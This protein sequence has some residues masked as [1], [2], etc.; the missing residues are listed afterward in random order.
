MRLVGLVA[1]VA[2]QVAFAG[3]TPPA[4]AKPRLLVLD[5]VPAGGVEPQVAGALTESVVAEASRTGYFEVSAQREMR[6]LVGL[7]RERA[8]MGCSEDSANCLAE[9][10]GAMGVRFVLSGTVARL[11]EAYQLTLQA[12]DSGK[13]Q[14]VGRS[15]RIAK[16]LG[17][18]L[19]SV[20]YA[21]A[22]ATA[23]PPPKPPSRVLPFTL[24]G[25]GGALVLVGGVVAFQAF[26]REDTLVSELKLAES[27][28]S[29]V[30]RPVGFYREEAR[31][32]ANQ[33]LIGS[34]L[35]GAGV[36]L[37]VTGLTLN[38]N[39]SSQIELRVAWAPGGPG[40]AM[41]GVF[42]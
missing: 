30:L 27:Q 38:L 40:V 33:K 10:A 39:L 36:A 4:P 41:A 5:L 15:T 35:S 9:M 22:E 3:T 1:L 28:P 32:I 20:P 34:L 13:A 21:L 16:D 24:I 29:V 42:P 26:M 11:G 7:E 12:L 19:S 25:G 18:L 37:L 23:T 6:T 2:A 14:P 31:R 8:L 17:A